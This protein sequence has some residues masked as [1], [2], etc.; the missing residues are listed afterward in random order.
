MNVESMEEEETR[1]NQSDDR[2]AVA[3]AASVSQLVLAD[4]FKA[5]ENTV[6]LDVIAG[7]TALFYTSDLQALF[8]DRWRGFSCCDRRWRRCQG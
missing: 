3:L 1:I 8:R 4:A 6:D 5:G 2:P 7:K